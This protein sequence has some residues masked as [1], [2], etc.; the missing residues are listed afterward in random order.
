MLIRFA[1]SPDKLRFF[2]NL[3]NAFDLLAVLPF[4]V[5]ILVSTLPSSVQSAYV[6]R[7]FRLLRLLR[8]VKIHRYSSA[9]QIFVQTIR[10]CI[11]DILT[12]AFLILTTTVVFASCSYYFEQE[13]QGTN[14]V[15]IPAACWW[16]VVTMSSVGYG[17]M[18]PVTIGKLQLFLVFSLH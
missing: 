16:A 18:V 1:A 17:D 15:S 14:F 5:T 7:V 11:S 4:Y 2:R 9:A 10:E 13:N 12:L 3:L 6:L 8:F